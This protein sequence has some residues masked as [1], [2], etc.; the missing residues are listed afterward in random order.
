MPCHV[1]TICPDE[2]IPEALTITRPVLG[3]NEEFRSCMPAVCVHRI[4][5]LPNG[6]AGLLEH[7]TTERRQ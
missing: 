4:A 1:P 6:L 2:L 3:G 7:P 5:L